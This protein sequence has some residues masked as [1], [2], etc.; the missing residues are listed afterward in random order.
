MIT[1][2]Q[3]VWKIYESSIGSRKWENKFHVQEGKNELGKINPYSKKGIIRSFSTTGV[4][5]PSLISAANF[6]TLNSQGYV[7][8]KRIKCLD[9]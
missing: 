4:D 9:F 5:S 6:A 7:S 8:E 1:K 3:I 2:T